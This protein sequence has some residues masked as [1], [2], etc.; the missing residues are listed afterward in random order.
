MALSARLISTLSSY[1]APLPTSLTLGNICFSTLEHRGRRGERRSAVC[2]SG[3]A[4]CIAADSRH[5][6]FCFSGDI[7]QSI[8]GVCFFGTTRPPLPSLI[9]VGHH[10]ASDCFCLI[11]VRKPM[12]I[13]WVSC[14]QKNNRG[15]V[16]ET[17]IRRLPAILRD[18]PALRLLYVLMLFS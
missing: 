18:P 13:G 8:P 10:M 11:Y 5:A 12:C 3:G 9:G 2:R 7:L 15:V 14:L 16:A 17:Y 6:Y 1:P 4:T